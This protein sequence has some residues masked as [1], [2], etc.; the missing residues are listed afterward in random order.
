MSQDLRLLMQAQPAV[1]ALAALLRLPPLL[2]QLFLLFLQGVDVRP[3]LIFQLLFPL[4]D[5]ICQRF[6]RFFMAANRLIQS[7]RFFR[8]Q[9]GG[10][11]FRFG[12]KALLRQSVGKV[13]FQL[14]RFFFPFSDVLP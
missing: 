14:C 11:V 1:A 3:R 8:R 4:A 7:F 9:T 10:T 6:F 5:P 2:G 13:F 12:L